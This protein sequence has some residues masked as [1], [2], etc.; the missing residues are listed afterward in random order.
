MLSKEQLELEILKTKLKRANYELGRT[1]TY[2]RPSMTYPVCVYLD[3][4]RWV[5]TLETHN[6][7]LKCPTAYGESPDQACNN[8]DHL[9]MGSAEFLV[10]QEDEEEQF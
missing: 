2:M 7:P 5:C 6:D 4:T 3:G 8:F 9:W 10:D 1:M